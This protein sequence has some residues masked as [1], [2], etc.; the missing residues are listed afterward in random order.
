MAKKRRRIELLQTQEKEV[1]FS[2]LDLD[3]F[4]GLIEQGIL[5]KVTEGQSCSAM[6]QQ[7][8]RN[9]SK[10]IPEPVMIESDAKKANQSGDAAQKAQSKLSE[11]E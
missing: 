7:S 6:I 11:E 10:A 1:A 3:Q 4:R 8:I 2:K 5:P 9:S